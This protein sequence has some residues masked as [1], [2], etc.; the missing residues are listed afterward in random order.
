MVFT[1]GMTHLPNLI[2][3][4]GLILMSAAAVTLLFKK[5]KQPVVLGYL[6]AGF[7]VGPTSPSFQQFVTPLVLRFGLKSV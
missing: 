6:L 3:D 4:L 5:L 7:L 1:L 2:I